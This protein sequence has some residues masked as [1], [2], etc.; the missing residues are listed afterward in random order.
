MRMIWKAAAV[1]LIGILGLSG[2]SSAQDEPVPS[3]ATAFDLEQTVENLTVRVLW[4]WADE[5]GI[6]VVWIQTFDPSKPGVWWRSELLHDDVV[7]HP[8]LD[9]HPLSYM[10]ITADAMTFAILKPSGITGEDTVTLELRFIGTQHNNGTPVPDAPTETM[11]FL[12]EVPF[13]HIRR[14]QGEQTATVNGISMTL[15]AVEYL[16]SDSRLTLCYPRITVPY[17]T[18]SREYDPFI[19]DPAVW[20]E[21]YAVGDRYE[22]MAMEFSPTLTPTP[23]ITPEATDEMGRPVPTA[24]P[25]TPTLTPEKCIDFGVPGL[26]PDEDGVLRIRID[27]LR[28]YMMPTAENVHLVN[29]ALEQSDSRWRVHFDTSNGMGIT[30]ADPTSPTPRFHEWRVLQN[31]VSDI[32]SER[33]LGPWTFSVPLE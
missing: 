29:A 26:I 20:T 5:E 22:W 14:W 12:L 11:S 3:Y 4:A 24:I 10:P 27:E 30:S 18:I 28:T 32:T 33:L 13:H 25:P 16:P 9:H 1:L 7:L 2:V 8:Y 31:V 6:E 15:K 23:V 19:D 21:R 17:Q